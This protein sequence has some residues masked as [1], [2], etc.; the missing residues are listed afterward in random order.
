MDDFTETGAGNLNLAI[1]DENID[2]L[3]S[4]IGTRIRWQQPWRCTMLEPEV[5]LQWMHEY[6]DTNATLGARFAVAGS[7]GFTTTGLDLGRDWAMIGTGVTWQKND[8]CSI[9]ANYDAQVKD[10]TALHAA[11][12]SLQ[13]TCWRAGSK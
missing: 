3:R 11:S 5:R 1:A 10:R 12:D 13:W 7:P 2:S 4:L 9:T 6:L 8:T